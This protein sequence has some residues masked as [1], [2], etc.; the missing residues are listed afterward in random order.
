MTTEYD[1]IGIASLLTPSLYNIQCIVENRNAPGSFLVPS[2][3]L[4][5]KMLLFYT[6]VVKDFDTRQSKSSVW[7]RLGNKRTL[8]NLLLTDFFWPLQGSGNKL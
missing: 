2:F 3:F 5:K 6:A 7:F 4:V 8:V 1:T